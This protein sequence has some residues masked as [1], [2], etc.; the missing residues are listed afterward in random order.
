MFSVLNIVK[1]WA[2]KVKCIIE[3]QIEFLWPKSKPDSWIVFEILLE[4]NRQTTFKM[5]PLADAINHYSSKGGDIHQDFMPWNTCLIDELSVN[6][7][8]F[9]K[10]CRVELLR[11]QL[12]DRTTRTA[13]LRL[14]IVG[15][16]SSVPTTPPHPITWITATTLH[17]L[18]NKRCFEVMLLFFVPTTAREQRKNGTTRDEA[19]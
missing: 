5:F 8:H 12:K 3:V 10:K 14:V 2:N 6:A 9:D 18:C 15:P 17:C 1:L 13:K 4:S 16:P 11:R 7:K 19:T